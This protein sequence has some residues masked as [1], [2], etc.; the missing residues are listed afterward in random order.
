[1]NISIIVSSLGPSIGFKVI[2]LCQRKTGSL[3]TL[4]KYYIYILSK[5]GGSDIY[6]ILFSEIRIQHLLG[7]NMRAPQQRSGVTLPSP[8]GCNSR[9]T[10]C[11][12]NSKDKVR[13]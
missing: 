11:S 7:M 1:L 9:T 8:G 13:K 12:G 2:T 5:A 10:M 6:F 4:L 3:L